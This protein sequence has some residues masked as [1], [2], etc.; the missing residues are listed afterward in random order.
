MQASVPERQVVLVTG[1]TGAI[2]QAIVRGIA[3]KNGFDVVVGCRNE[4]KGRDLARTISRNLGLP[5]LRVAC[6]DVSSRQ[7]IAGLRRRW[8]GPLHVL[9]NNAVEAPRRRQET[10][11]G[12][13]RQFATNV[14]GYFWMMHAFFDLLAASAPARVVNVASYYAGGLDLDDLEFKRRPYDNNA[15]YRQ[16]KQADRMLAAAFAA[17][18]KEAS[19]NVNACHSG[20]VNSTVSNSLGFGGHETPEEGAEMPITLATGPEGMHNTGAY[21]EHGRLRTCPFAED[22]QAVDRLVDICEAY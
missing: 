9:I 16:S 3:A 1:A 11:A 8:E 5:E 21:F 19:I 7:S 17:R 22:R 14:L 20:D 10:S 6:V 18:W 12:I 15:A 13:E 4:Q 2:G